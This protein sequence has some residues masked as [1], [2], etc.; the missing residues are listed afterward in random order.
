MG[1]R[2]LALGIVLHPPCFLQ[3][4]LSLGPE[5]LRLGK[6]AGSPRDL[7][8][9]ASPVWYISVQQHAKPFTWMLGIDLRFSDLCGQYFKDQ[10]LFPVLTRF[11]CLFAVYLISSGAQSVGPNVGSCIQLGRETPAAGQLELSWVL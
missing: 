2:G 6:V 5:A 4:G 7:S 9:S 1:A 3:Q 8:V 10:A 11:C